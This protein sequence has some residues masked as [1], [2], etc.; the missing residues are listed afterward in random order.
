MKQAKKQFK[1]TPGQTYW[2][3]NSEVM[4]ASAIW[5]DTVVHW[6]RLS[7]GNCF[8][9]SEGEITEYERM[10]RNITSGR[11]VVVEAPE[12]WDVVGVGTNIPDADSEL[13]AHSIVYFKRIM[14]PPKEI[15]VKVYNIAEHGEPDTRLGVYNFI[16]PGNYVY[17]NELEGL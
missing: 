12:G 17:V 11:S 4:P 1:P 8:E 10:L 2:Y 9:D 3:L 15:V 13:C 7:V 5:A 14:P 16:Y 6:T